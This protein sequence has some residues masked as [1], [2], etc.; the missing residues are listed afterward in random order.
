MK[1]QIYSIFGKLLLMFVG[2]ICLSSSIWAGTIT[3]HV[4]SKGVKTNQ[5][6]VVYIDTIEGKDFPAPQEPVLCD[7]KE[8]EFAPHVL[9]ILKGTTVDFLNS[10]AFAHNHGDKVRDG[11]T[12]LINWEKLSFF[13]I[14]IRKWKGGLLFFQPPILP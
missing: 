3:G 6:A 8:K 5:W 10:D 14:Y 13:V 1:K 9:P 7:Q 12:L 2:F 4:E 11:R